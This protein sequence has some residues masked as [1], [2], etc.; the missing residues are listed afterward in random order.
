ML[1]VKN[2]LKIF[3]ELNNSVYFENI[4][5]CNDPL[6]QGHIVRDCPAKMKCFKC[7]RKHHI[8]ICDSTENNGRNEN[9][10]NANVVKTDH[11]NAV[12]LQTARAFVCSTDE[13]NSANLRILFDSGSMN[14]FITPRARKM[15]HLKATG[16][17]E[18][19]IKAFGGSRVT[20]KLD[21][22]K[23]CVKSKK[24]DLNI[25]LSAFVNEICQPLANQ[26][27]K[28]ARENYPYLSDLEL[29]DFNYDDSSMDIDI[30]I[31]ADYY[32]QF[33]ENYTVRSENG[34]GPIA[35]A[36][37]LGFI[38]SGPIMRKN[39]ETSSANF[40]SSIHV[41][42][43]ENEILNEKNELQKTL[44][45]FWS[46]ESLGISPEESEN[47]NHGEFTMKNA[48]VLHAFNSEVNINT[49][50]RYE[51]KLPFKAN[52]EQLHDNYQNSK[53]RLRNLIKKFHHNPELLNAYNDIISE[54]E[55]LNI[56]EKVPESSTVDNVHYLPHRPVVRDDKVTTKT[57]MVFDA[58]AKL[59]G[60]SLNDCLH[61]GPSLTTALY[62]T[63]IKFRE[64]NIALVADIEKAFLQISL[65]PEHRDF[66]RFLWFEDPVNI[67]YKNFDNNKLV[68]Y[69]LT[70]VLFGVTSSPFLLS[71]TLIKH[72]NSFLQI[73]PEFVRK[74]LDSLHVDDLKGT[75]HLATSLVKN[76]LYVTELKNS[77]I[78]LH[79]SRG[80]GQTTT[81]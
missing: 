9:E 64:N 35:L 20:N 58:S 56:I 80:Y 69:R 24:K 70:R 18:M 61:A 17:K 79:I 37:K 39:D 57:R 44:S 13:R 59:K 7:E 33:I 71:A 49:E 4:L 46:L 74:I 30:L 11:S 55:N 26:E 41:L 12:L 50:G 60:P 32:W 73:D 48:D 42:K 72:I 19:T 81:K 47:I 63:L 14:S 25:Y 3:S 5:S 36:S 34:V 65:D 38:L 68:E 1:H 6:R 21:V 52:H 31:G 27:I 8:S 77:T 66:V 28:F 23:F 2:V 67:D 54:Q 76:I 15:L 43:V 40:I 53:N 22:V 78:I 75:A 62:D 45:N 51:V 16:A 10:T 29:A